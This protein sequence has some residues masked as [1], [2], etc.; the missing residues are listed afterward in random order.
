MEDTIRPLQMKRIYAD[1]TISK[2]RHRPPIIINSKTDRKSTVFELII[3]GGR[4]R[5]LQMVPSAYILFI[6]NGRMVSSI[7]YSSLTYLWTV[8]SV[9]ELIIVCGRC[10]ALQMVSSA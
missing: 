10:R 8:S 1:G 5:P 7:F 6:C 4:C 3:I 2:G 9:F